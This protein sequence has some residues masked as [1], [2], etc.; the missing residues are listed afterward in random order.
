MKRDEHLKFCKKCLN[1]SFNSTKGIVCGLTGEIASFE[2]ECP[3]YKLD[4]SA[5][6]HQSFQHYSSVDLLINKYFVRKGHLNDR[7][8]IFFFTFVYMFSCFAVFIEVGDTSE[9]AGSLIIFFSKV[10][11]VFIGVAMCICSIVLFKLFAS[12]FKKNILLKQLVCLIAAGIVGFFSFKFICNLLLNPRKRLASV[13]LDKD[14]RTH[15]CLSQKMTRGQHTTV[16]SSRSGDDA[17]YK[18]T[19]WW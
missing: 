16:A 11:F 13:L 15:H 5:E 10:K 8:I 12:S 17:R 6:E 18:R 2:N 7:A 4:S 1:R 3:D 9:F 19:G 14:S